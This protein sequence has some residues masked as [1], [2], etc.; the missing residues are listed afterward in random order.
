MSSRPG[1]DAWRLMYRLLFDGEAH[2]RM[3]DVAAEIGLT[4]NLLKTLFHLDGEQGTRMKDLADHWKCDA[5]YVTSVIDQLE[6]KGLAERRPHPG[7]RRVKSAM[8]T[9]AGAEAKS[10]AL[11][12]LFEPPSAFSALTRAEQRQLRDLMQKVVDADP[13]IAGFHHRHASVTGS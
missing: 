4:P 12:R 2:R 11:E 13:L 7:D 10:Q 9:A 1:A 8:L 6:K 5:S 3:H